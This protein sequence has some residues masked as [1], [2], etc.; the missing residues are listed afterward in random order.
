MASDRPTLAR[1]PLDSALILR[2]AGRPN[3]ATSRRY[4]GRKPGRVKAGGE[5]A[6]LL[7]GHPLVEREPLGH[8][9]HAAA[10]LQPLRGAVQAQHF[11]LPAVRL[12]QAQEDADGCRLARPV[13]AQQGEDRPGGH[14]QGEAIQGDLRPKTL[15]NL[16][17]SNYR[18]HG[19]CLLSLDGRQLVLDQRNATGSVRV[20]SVVPL[21]D[22]LDTAAEQFQPLVLAASAGPIRHR[23]AGAA[24]AL[25]DAVVL[26]LTI[27]PEQPC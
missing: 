13:L 27:A 14:F 10:N 3:C 12:G 1:M 8:V 24:D 17:K 6:N 22:L 11:A 5:P 23:Q 25:Q 21:R 7:D 18:G 26:Q 9:A 15:G 2:R 4:S 16:V 19:S 20:G